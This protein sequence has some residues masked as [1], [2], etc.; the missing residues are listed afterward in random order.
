[1]NRGA[2]PAASPDPLPRPQGRHDRHRREDS[3]QVE[4]G[5]RAP[6]VYVVPDKQPPA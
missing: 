1:M 2:M 3:R 6:S 4:I 5:Y